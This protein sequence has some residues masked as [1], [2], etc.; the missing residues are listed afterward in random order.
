MS[1]IR[2]FAGHAVD[3]GATLICLASLAGVI[4]LRQLSQQPAR[5]AADTEQGE[6]APS[7]GN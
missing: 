2:R 4:G 1:G 3:A 7:G 6:E 5:P